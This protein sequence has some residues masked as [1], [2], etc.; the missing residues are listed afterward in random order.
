M[1]QYKFLLDSY[2]P[3][4]SHHYNFSTCP[5]PS[6]SPLSV[7]Q[8]PDFSLSPYTRTDPE[9]EISDFL[10]HVCNKTA[11][12]YFKFRAFANNATDA[13]LLQ[14]LVDPAHRKNIIYES[15]GSDSAFRW[16]MNVASSA[17]LLGFRV[18]LVFSLAEP[19]L[20]IKR[21]IFR[22]LDTD[23]RIPC[24][25]FIRST[26]VESQRNFLEIV[27][28]LPHLTRNSGNF[29]EAAFEARPFESVLFLDTN[30]GPHPV[31]F[32][33]A[34]NFLHTNVE[35][36]HRYAEYMPYITL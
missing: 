12:V 5:F 15:T 20:L 24:P 10:S 32:W 6:G 1:A 7:E 23:G 9:S 18:H 26:H 11:S 16:F 34:G 22:A 3:L 2:R 19:A 14:H 31:F 36:L 30:E 8:E 28:K 35:L 25:E 29:E 17:R 33:K 13:A 4:L 27:K 21:A